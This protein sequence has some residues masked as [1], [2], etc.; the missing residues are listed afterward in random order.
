VP[1]WAYSYRTTIP[2]LVAAGRRC[3]AP[4]RAEFGRSD[5]PGDIVCH[6]IARHTGI[7]SSLV[8]APARNDIA[9]VCQDRGDPPASRRPP[10]SPSASRGSAP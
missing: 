9:R 7:L 3:I 4:D 2:P 5:K 1:S 6:T 10:C 8:N